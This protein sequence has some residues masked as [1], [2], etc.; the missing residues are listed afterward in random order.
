MQVHVGL[1]LGQPVVESAECRTRPLGGRKAAGHVTNERQRPARLLMIRFHGGDGRLDPVKRISDRHRFAG[2]ERDDE[3]EEDTVFLRHVHEQLRL[4]SLERPLQRQQ[5]LRQVVAVAAHDLVQH[6]VQPRQLDA[7]RLVI[8]G[9]DVPDERRQALVGPH[10]FLRRRR[11]R[12]LQL[13]HER[14]DV[15]AVGRARLREWN[16]AA[17]AVVDLM[18]LEDTDGRGRGCRDLGNGGF[19][20]NRHGRGP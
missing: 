11:G 4:E 1:E 13:F 8:A 9:L 17:A 18:V 16:L 19:W 20:C 12:R 5:R 10:R 6:G 3:R 14:V 2:L 15:Q 7:Q